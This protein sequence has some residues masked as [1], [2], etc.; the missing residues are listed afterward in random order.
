MG[1]V[2]LLNRRN[3]QLLQFN[4]SENEDRKKRGRRYLINTD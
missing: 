4:E 1:V 3:L 2:L